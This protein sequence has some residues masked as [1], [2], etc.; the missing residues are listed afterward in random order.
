MSTRSLSADSSAK[1]ISNS[2]EKTVNTGVLP[3]LNSRASETGSDP[4]L[5]VLEIA[6]ELRCSKAHVYNIIRNRV[7]RVK[8]LPTIA[9]GRKKLIRRSSFEAWKRLNETPVVDAT[10]AAK[11]E[12]NTVDA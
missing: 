8:P 9:L 5:T 6:R 11:S 1:T 4:V 10:L 7:P 2:I 12:V 3:D